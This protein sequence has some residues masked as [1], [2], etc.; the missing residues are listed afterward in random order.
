MVV[1]LKFKNFIIPLLQFGFVYV[2]LWLVKEQIMRNLT[3]MQ[4]KSSYMSAFKCGYYFCVGA[5]M[6]V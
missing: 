1:F 6:I 2:I 3:P 5:N 4:S